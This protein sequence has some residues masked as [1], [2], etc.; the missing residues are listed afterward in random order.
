LVK[1]RSWPNTKWTS[2]IWTGSLCN[3]MYLKLHVTSTWMPYQTVIIDL[4]LCVL[5]NVMF[6]NAYLRWSQTLKAWMASAQNLIN[7]CNLYSLD[8]FHTLWTLW[9]LSLHRKV[10]PNSDPFP[11]SLSKIFENVLA[12]QIQLFM[13]I[14][15]MPSEKQSGFKKNR[16]CHY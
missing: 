15:S 9:K 12:A 13:D 14:N 6:L 10:K 7:C 1:A 16:S 8:I 3:S 11:D 2:T 4:P 5:D